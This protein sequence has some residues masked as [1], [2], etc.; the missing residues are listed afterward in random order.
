LGTFRHPDLNPNAA[1]VGEFKSRAIADN[2]LASTA[3][4]VFICKNK[5]VEKNASGTAVR[6]GDREFLA[7]V[8][9]AKPRT[10]AEIGLIKKTKNPLLGL[11]LPRVIRRVAASGAADVAALELEPGTLEKLCLTPITLDRIRDAG[12]AGNGLQCR[13]AGFPAGYSVPHFP[14]PEARAFNMLAYGCEAIEPERWHNITKQAGTFNRDLDVVFCYDPK[15]VVEYR[16]D[17]PV[18]G[19]LPHP[20]GTSGGGIWQRRSIA[21]DDEIWSPVAFD[22]I[23]IQSAMLEGKPYLKAT[24]IIH[25]LKLVADEYPDLRNTLESRYSRLAAL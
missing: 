4:Y 7:T 13:L 3:V 16:T 22:L 1:D 12:T 25:W 2:L 10:I 18:P 19:G 5:G 17:A 8:R 15:E 9:H 6:I 24:Q 11:T 23:A 20:G 21:G 14:A